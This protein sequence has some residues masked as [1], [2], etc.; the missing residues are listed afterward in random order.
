MAGEVTATDN[1]DTEVTVI[2]NEDSTP[3]G[4]GEQ[5]TRTWTA[6]DACG[7]STVATQEIS[8]SDT[9]APT[10][11]NV[12]ADITV[13]CDAVPLSANPDVEDNCDTEVSISVEDIRTDGECSFSY[14]LTR[15]WTAVDD[16][17]NE[18]T[19]IQIITVED[20]EAPELLNVPENITSECTEIPEVPVAGEV[21]A[22]DNCDTEVTVTF[23]EDSTPNGC[24]EQITRTWTATDACGNSTV[25]T[26]EIS[27]SDTEAPQVSE[28][29]ADVIVEC[30]EI[31]S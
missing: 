4:C 2:F 12:P 14:E 25:A 30:N 20:T 9:E 6:T 5:I 23:N 15:T 8:V 24:G 17:G 26:Q 19:A 29:P 7:N 18:N 28:V 10:I 16:C 11:T 3:N 27:V 1:C 22:T 31:P 21:T 13:E